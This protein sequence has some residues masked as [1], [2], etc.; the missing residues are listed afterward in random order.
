MNSM[1]RKYVDLELFHPSDCKQRQVIR[2]DLGTYSRM[3][4]T[5]LPEM[6]CQKLG[7]PSGILI[8]LVSIEGKLSEVELWAIGVK[9]NEKQCITLVIPSKN[10]ETILG[11]LTLAQLGLMYNKLRAYNKLTPIIQ[12]YDDRVFNS[13]IYDFIYDV[14]ESLYGV[15][16]AL[17]VYEEVL[18][19]YNEDWVEIL[20]NNR[21]HLLKE[22]KRS[23]FVVWF[24]SMYLYSLNASI[25]SMLT[26]LYPYIAVIF[27]QAL[28]G[29]VA[30]YVADTHKNFTDIS[31][32]IQRWDTVFDE[33]EKTGF[34]N[35]VDRYF[36]ND[37]ELAD[38]I[39]SLWKTLSHL[40]V[41]ARGILYTFPEVSSIAMGL[42]LVAYVE[43]DK[44]PLS[45]LNDSIKKFHEIFK[46]I[47]DKWLNTWFMVR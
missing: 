45:I 30:A 37:K 23:S 36:S 28:E 35:V 8:G 34:K 11:F 7:E 17:A 21:E 33:I 42:P 22:W 9:Y 39:S 40:F 2:F 25:I 13:F 38:E 4:Y 20:S 14:F 31:D 27:R 44:K 29:L 15:G 43:G 26:G 18:K 19:Q 3:L 10:G 41:H 5:V 1:E 46:K 24:M 32:P 12:V 16:E 6:I 47:F